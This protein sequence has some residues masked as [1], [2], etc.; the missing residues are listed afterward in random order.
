MTNQLSQLNLN[1]TYRLINQL[2]QNKFR[3]ITHSGVD[4]LFLHVWLKVHK[5]QDDQLDLSTKK[6][7]NSVTFHIQNETVLS[8]LESD[9]RDFQSQN[10]SVETFFDI[11]ILFF[12]E[13]GKQTYFPVR[14]TKMTR[15]VIIICKTKADKF[16][17][18][19]LVDLKSEYP[20]EMSLK[21]IMS[22]Y[23]I[24]ESVEIVPNHQFN[25]ISIE[26][27]Y[28]VCIELYK[29]NGN[30]CQLD[31]A[32]PGIRH[33]QWEPKHRIRIAVDNL[34]IPYLPRFFWVPSDQLISKEYFCTK[35][36]GKCGYSTLILAK[37]QRHEKNCSD[38]TE[39]EAKQVFSDFASTLFNIRVGLLRS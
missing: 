8:L 35:L 3:M 26:E 15:R 39:I 36:P 9:F 10:C 21:S 16:I 38:E 1:L 2:T 29:K 5:F 20:I 4:P 12:K 27:K 24:H 19:S 32:L 6:I 7:K 22:I 17:N 18:K 11:D 25:V 23:D 28:H 30:M 33:P 37:L 34:D 31:Y 14:R 13:N